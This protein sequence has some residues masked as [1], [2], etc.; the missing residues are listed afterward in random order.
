MRIANFKIDNLK[1]RTKILIPLALM[2]A[3]VLVV[4]AFGATRLMRVSSMASVIIER[5]DLAAMEI[6][7]ASH[8]MAAAPHAVFAILLYDKDDPQRETSKKEYQ[9][10]VPDS[11]ALL[12]HAATLLP[13]RAAE[14]AKFKKRF[15][16]LA[17][18]AKDAFKVSV[19]T[20]G[21]LH[22]LEIQQADLVQEELGA[23]LATAADMR[24]ADLTNEMGAFNEALLTAN[25]KASQDLNRLANS[26]IVSMAA[27]GI[28]A[29][30]LAGAFAM[31][32]TTFKVARPLSRMVER[33][34]TLAQGDL[35]VETEGVGRRDEVG[36][37]AAAVE[38]FK[39][40][41][42]QRVKMEKEAAEQR[43]AGDA[44][45]E[46]VEAEKARGAEAQSRAM[47]WLGEALKRVADGDL[48][49]RLDPH[50]PSE[51]AKI[52]ADFNAAAEK[53]M[54][55]VR[56]VVSSTSA[57]HSGAREITSASDDLSRRTEQQAASLEDTAAALDEISV[58]LNH[59]AASAKHASEVVA[60]A[61]DDAKKGAIV[62]KQAVE[63]V[64]AISR[65]SE[66]IGRILS[67]IDEIAFQTNLLALN[68][69]VEAARAGDAGKGFA[70]VASEVRALAQRSAEAAKDIKHLISTSSKQVECG[71]KL[72]AESGKAFERI[73]DQVSEI[74]R[75]VA[76]IATGAQEQATGIQQINA[77]INGMDRS[78]Q[79]NA[80]IA[81]ES[82]AASHSLSQ[83]MTR[84]AGLVEQFR[85]GGDG[86]AATPRDSQGVAPYPS[87]GPAQ[88]PS[89]RAG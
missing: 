57:I 14:I 81:E 50:F 27:A 62:V 22:G 8:L 41:A 2:A 73:I 3:G 36:E 64:D 37:M 89:A 87:A 17:E 77:T 79:Q 30:L 78:T 71:A 67:V 4:A 12:D 20:P 75:V 88:A 49:T 32:M 5:R 54:E 70:V 9:T 55:T 84:L 7:R 34:K 58:T 39:T 25:A 76:D 60:S 31:W 16:T 1:L 72:V 63:A 83:E 21:L 29:T 59:S 6:A 28:A 11:V 47:S 74:N 61:D 66:Q 23:R 42:I 69:G 38:V 53:L 85:V 65:S 33:M 52:R 80:T 15:Q 45:R 46:R 18:D 26:A 35:N 43:A 51:F 44:E 19:G 10:L 13:D 68:A 82:T 40:N 56:V 86:G 48:T 24:I